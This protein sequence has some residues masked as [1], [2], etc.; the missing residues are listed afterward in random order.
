[1][2]AANEKMFNTAESTLKNTENAKYFLYGGKK[3]RRTC[4][5]SFIYY[6]NGLLKLR[7]TTIQEKTHQ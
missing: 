4:R 3:R 2:S 7:H 5:N 6:T 1:M